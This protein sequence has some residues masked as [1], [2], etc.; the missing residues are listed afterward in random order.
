MEIKVEIEK[1]TLQEDSRTIRL[2]NFA[3][4]P[5]SVSFQK[6]KENSNS[7]RKVLWDY[8]TEFQNI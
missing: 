8:S 5:S 2:Q 3:L 1:K 7:D 4:K 6:S